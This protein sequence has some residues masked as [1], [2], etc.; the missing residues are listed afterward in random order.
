M[1]KK[2]KLLFKEY[3][4]YCK[5]NKFEEEWKN[6]CGNLDNYSDYLSSLDEVI[7]NLEL[8]FEWLRKNKKD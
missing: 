8:F 7:A 5:S 1:E 4:Q 6:K 3:I 2:F